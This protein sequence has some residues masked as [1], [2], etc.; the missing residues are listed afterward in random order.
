MRE[1]ETTR[2][3]VIFDTG[4]KYSNIPSHLST[5]M[6]A[7]HDSRTLIANHCSKHFVCYRQ[8]SHIGVD[9]LGTHP[10]ACQQRTAFFGPTARIGAVKHDIVHADRAV[11]QRWVG[12]FGVRACDRGVPVVQLDLHELEI[13]R[14]RISIKGKHF[15]RSGSLLWE[16]RNSDLG[17][18][19]LP[20]RHI[21]AGPTQPRAIS[22]LS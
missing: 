2:A 12:G 3:A 9:A 10:H 11:S 8:K 14:H 7:F 22:R 6:Y 16:E 17:I 5:P 21:A 18:L 13:L 1:R 19:V 20:I 4:D 15:K